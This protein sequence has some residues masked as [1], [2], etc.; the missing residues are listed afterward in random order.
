MLQ[1]GRSQ[2]RSA[3]ICV[4]YHASGIDQRHQP[5]TKR[6]PQLTFNRCRQA[7]QRKVQRLFVKLSSRNFL[8]QSRQ[9]HP[10]TIRDGRMPFPPNEHPGPW[11][12]KKFVD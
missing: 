9:H 5:V 10:D 11:F 3:Q 1:R 4:K 7:V 12:A 8:P 2:R 6:M